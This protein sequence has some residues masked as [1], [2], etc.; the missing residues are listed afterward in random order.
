[1][2]YDDDDDDDPYVPRI[3]PAAM[4]SPRSKFAPYYSGHADSFEDFLEE[5]EALAYDCALTDPQRVDVIIRYVDPSMREFW[6][7]LNGYRSRD[8]PLFRQSLVNIFGNPI[9]RHQIMRQKLHSHVQ[10]S[11]RRRMDCEDDVSQYYRQFLCY[12]APLVH[13]GHLSEEERDAAF[14]YGFH[15]EDR[16][17]VWPRLLGK[18]PLQ[19][20]D[21]PFH[22]E[23]VF[24]C[25]RAAFAYD[26]YFPSPW[27]HAKQFEPLSLRR[28]QPVVEPAPR[29][30]YS[31]RAVTRPVATYAETTPDDGDLSPSSSPSSHSTPDSDLPHSLI[32]P[33]ESPYTQAPSVTV[34]QPETAP[35]LSTTLRPSASF[36]TPD[37]QLPSSSSPSI[38][39]SQHGLVHSVTVDQPEP[40]PTLLSTPPSSSSISPTFVPSATE[41]QSE[42]STPTLFPSIPTLPINPSHVHSAI[43][44]FAPASTSM[45]VPLLSLPLST[46]HPLSPLSSTFLPSPVT[47]VTEEQPE[48]E[49][50]STPSV[51]PASTFASTPLSSPTFLPSP[52]RLATEDQPEPESASTPSITPS[53]P[54]LLSRPSLPLEFTDDIREFLSPLPTPFSTSL[55][56]SEYSTSLSSPMKPPPSETSTSTPSGMRSLRS[57]PHS[58]PAHSSRPLRSSSGDSSDTVVELVVVPVSLNSLESSLSSLCEPVLHLPASLEPST[59]TPTSTTSQRPPRPTTSGLISPAL[60]VTPVFA[61]SA[62]IYEVSST[63]AAPRFSHTPSPRLQSGSSFARLTLALSFVTIA[64]IVSVLLNVSKI[65][66]AHERKASKIKDLGSNWKKTSSDFAHRLRLGQNT[67]RAPRLVFDPGGPA[68]SSRLPSAHEDVRKR[69][70]KTRDGCT[71]L[72]TGLPHSRSNR[73]SH[74]FRSPEVLNRFSLGHL[75][76]RTPGA[77]TTNTARRGHDTDTDTTPQRYDA[78]TA[79]RRYDTDSALRGHDTDAAPQRYDADTALR[80]YDTDSALRGHDIDAAPQGHDTDSAPRGHDT[81]AAPQALRRY[82]TDSAL[83]G[84]D[85]DAAPQ[86]YDADTALR[87][88]DTDSALRGHDI[89]AA[90]RGHDTDAAPRG[91][92]TDA[93]PRGHD[94]NA[95]P[96]G[97]DTDA[98]PRGHDTDTALRHYDTDS[99]LRGHDIDAAPRGHDTD[100]APRN[101]DTNAAP[102]GHDTDAA[103]RGHD[104]DAALRRYDTDSAP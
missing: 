19:P 27:S 30:A 40:A 28:E 95:A 104:T 29:D 7:S 102:Q 14:W 56:C 84:H 48:P 24:D 23:D 22:F 9:P 10:D 6:K 93:A 88:Y 43:D 37:P 74:R 70:L 63:L 90:P 41:H 103:P 39:E 8:W 20:P 55:A 38:L 49:L 12:S 68:S 65:A 86:C 15:P 61:L 87:R 71:T 81:D 13:T 75:T 76:A 47:S 79:L 17:V 98:A 66:S 72:D 31:F 94:T 2:Y 51:S 60:E 83:R 100:A 46:L 35:T 42:P 52:A 54:A 26:N 89:D 99:S 3:G 97:L 11:S 85:T 32:S 1:M 59:T 4:P 77:A 91:H 73:Q 78:D 21:V 45:S 101:H 25:A 96:R 80:R 69:I 5:F 18:N 53:S 57:D 62:L 92:D 64:A 16:K 82:D 34:D 36:P 58:V 44:H 67:P 33:S 50:E